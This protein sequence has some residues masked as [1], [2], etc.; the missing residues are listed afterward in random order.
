M[1]KLLLLAATALI[2][3]G[4]LNAQTTAM[5]FTQMDCSGTSRNLFTDLNAG[6]VVIM[7]WYMGPSC[8]PCKDAAKE[9]EG[10]KTKLLA[11]YPGKVMSYAWGFQDSYTCSAT[12][13]WVSGLG[14]SAIPMDTGA[15][16]VAYYGGFSMPTV[17]VVGGTDHKVLY[18]ANPGNGGY[19]N[20]DT[21]KMRTAIKNFFS[22]TA[23]SSL[24]SN[25]SNVSIFPSPAQSDVSIQLQ[26]NAATTIQV[27]VLSLNGQVV[28]QL[29]AE[30]VTG[31]YARKLNT[32][33]LA[34]GEYM[35][36]IAADG[37][38]ITRRL[39]IVK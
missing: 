14:S 34:A 9:I 30:K 35:V 23:V 1:K 39:S 13:S 28:M 11:T 15:A 2:S 18:I 21:S 29:P 32:Q 36:R 33:I 7:E 4:A 22:P 6:K 10:L 27:Q 8:Q 20:G 26:T 19:S 37:E 16:M 25:I 17:V 38:T 31:N 5:D 12:Q 24:P 3:A